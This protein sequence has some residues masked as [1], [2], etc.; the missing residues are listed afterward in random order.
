M[1]PLASPY[2]QKNGRGWPRPV[3]CLCVSTYQCPP[4]TVLSVKWMPEPVNVLP[5]S[6]QTLPVPVGLLPEP[7]VVIG[8][9]NFIML[10]AYVPPNV[11]FDT[12]ALPLVPQGLTP[13]PPVPPKLLSRMTALFGF[14]KLRYT[15]VVLLPVKLEPSTVLLVIFQKSIAVVVISLK[16]TSETVAFVRPLAPIASVG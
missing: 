1:P 4:Q 6:S 9:P 8:P 12:V 2:L 5:P 15:A 7:D 16:C 13:I 10:P 11:L 3:W 14:S